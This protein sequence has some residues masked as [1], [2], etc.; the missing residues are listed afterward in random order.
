MTTFIFF[1]EP[2][3]IHSYN[4]GESM[5]KISISVPRHAIKRIHVFPPQSKIH[6]IFSS[7][8]TDIKPKEWEKLFIRAIILD[9]G[10]ILLASKD[11]SVVGNMLTFNNAYIFVKVGA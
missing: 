2:L 7:K 8:F 4:L 6:K 1:H 11:F 10:G 9:K 3:S 5:E